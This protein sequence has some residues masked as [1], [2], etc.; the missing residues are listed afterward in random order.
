MNLY[1]KSVCVWT[2][3]Q[4]FGTNDWSKIQVSQT[5]KNM[6][7]KYSSSKDYWYAAR[8]ISLAGLSYRSQLCFDLPENTVCLH[9]YLF[10]L[11]HPREQI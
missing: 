6:Q 9:V 7:N 5:K 2:I 3:F 10:V 4:G 11:L 1:L 8:H